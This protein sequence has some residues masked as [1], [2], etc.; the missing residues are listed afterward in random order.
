MAKQ[1]MKKRKRHS[2]TAVQ[3][4]GKKTVSIITSPRKAATKSRKL[5]FNILESQVFCMPAH[6]PIAQIS[7][8]PPPSLTKKPCRSSLSS[9]TSKDTH[10]FAPPK[11]VEQST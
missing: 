11:L 8:L 10:S 6:K 4:L 1:P 7:G 5:H 2:K 3:K 9:R